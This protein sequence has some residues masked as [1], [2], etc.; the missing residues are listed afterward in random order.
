MI[1]LDETSA[2]SLYMQIYGQVKGQILSG[3]IKEGSRLPSIRSLSVSLGVSK[4]TVKVAYHQLCSE[5]YLVNRARRGFF[6]QRIDQELFLNLNEK[7][8]G[9]AA[10]A[11]PLGEGTRSSKQVIRYDFQYGNLN[12]RDFPMGIWRKIAN[13]VLSPINSRS[14]ASYPER[15]GECGLR[16]E[17]MKYLH[18]SRGVSCRAN[19]II[20]CSGTRFSLGLICQMLKEEFGGVAMEEPGYDGARDVFVNCGLEVAPVGHW[21]EGLDLGELT[22]SKARLLYLTPSHQFP[23]GSVMSIRKR[24]EL[25]DWA[26]RNAAIII[27]DDYDSEL[28]YGG[29]PIPSIQS[30]DG[31]G[32]VIYL[33][34]FSKSLSPALRLSYM[35]LPHPLLERF[36]EKFRKYVTGAPWLEQKILTSF[37]ADGHW[38][39]HLRKV[40]LANR[41]RHDVLIR[42]V[43]RVMAGRVRLHGKNAGLHVLL[44]FKDG[45]FE[46]ERLRQAGAQGVRVYPA[47]HYWIHRERYPGNMVLMGFGS[48]AEKEIEEG[49]CL[50]GDAWFGR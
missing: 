2:T 4:N 41:K 3:R 5:G 8:A 12:P 46:G 15:Q 40:C 19:Q 30:I 7:N 20:V 9:K 34:T 1:V 14:M 50:L 29:R 25:L 48:L 21:E 39:R 16:T 11:R 23:T 28:R 24:L 27:E 17:I 47:A 22:Q 36:Y 45:S 13:Q 10:E 42:S 37:M 35:V 6:S 18:M 31:R 43:E 26:E 32:R 38:E 44:E 33:G 49:V